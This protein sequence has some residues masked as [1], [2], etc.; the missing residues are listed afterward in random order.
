MYMYIDTVFT[1]SQRNAEARNPGEGRPSH[2]S[3]RR[4][5]PRAESTD[6]AGWTSWGILGNIHIY[7]YIYIYIYTYTYI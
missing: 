7:I 5:A 3:S 2:R 4:P 1:V 6:A